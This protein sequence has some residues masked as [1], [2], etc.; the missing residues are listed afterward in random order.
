MSLEELACC[1][2][3]GAAGLSRLVGAEGRPVRTS[4]AWP[5]SHSSTPH[6]FDEI[7]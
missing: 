6:W 4:G 1:G 2:D 5:G 7:A 3:D